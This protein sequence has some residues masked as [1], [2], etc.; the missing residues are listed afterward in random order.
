MPLSILRSS[1]AYGQ[2]LPG[3]MF[4]AVR[5]EGGR[6]ARVA[7]PSC[8]GIQR[9][10]GTGDGFPYSAPLPY[11]PAGSEGLGWAELESGLGFPADETGMAERGGAKV[12]I[13]RNDV[14]GL[15]AWR[16]P[17]GHSKKPRLLCL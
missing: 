8:P 9:G 10:R 12:Q 4:P 6:P 13:L 17:G 14:V 2:L 3:L 16:V 1:E 5:A 11:F 7:S 15:C